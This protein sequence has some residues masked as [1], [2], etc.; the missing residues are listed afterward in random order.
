MASF[1]HAAGGAVTTNA[2]SYT[3]VSFTP[4]ANDLLFLVMV[5]TGS[6]AS[7]W[8]VTDS[9][10]GTWTKIRRQL[11]AASTDI[12][13]LWVRD[14][15]TPASAMTVT[16]SHPSGNATGLASE[17]VRVSGMTRT[18]AAAIRSHGGEDNQAAGGTPAPVLSQ[19]A[20]AANPTFGVVGNASNPAGLTAPAGWTEA[21][22]VGYAT[23]TTGFETV[24][25]N[26][27]FTGTTVTWGSTSATA[28][29]SL[30]FEFDTST[31]FTK[32]VAVTATATATVAK[33]VTKKVIATTTATP[34]VAKRVGHAVVLSITATP[35]FGKR[36]GRRVVAA[37][38][39]APAFG[40]RV[41][42]PAALAITASVGIGRTIR[43]T[44]ALA[45]TAAAATAKAVGHR[46]VGSV[47]LIID[48]ATVTGQVFQHAIEVTTEMVIASRRVVTHGMAVAVTVV[49]EIRRT[50]GHAVAVALQ[51]LPSFTSV[52]QV[53]QRRCDVLMA[54]VSRR[55]S[56]QA[57]PDE[58]RRHGIL[59]SSWRRG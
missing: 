20:L 6:T 35:A 44:A 34:A 58:P 59:P 30:I 33:R 32:A 15:L 40:K 53:I 45:I 8:T 29:A 43:H 22:D 5:L 18:G 27:G 41:S 39:A 10:G 14:Q 46:V 25:R 13:E 1:T 24:A 2:A 11:K 47:D 50:I 4:A 16:V 49:A 55:Q 38:V 48:I 17:I 12:L 57:T 28:F 37:V 3:S 19:A 54:A 7:D 26:A 51:A 9:L 52:A 23:P 36:V 21:V 56:D 42:H 31:V